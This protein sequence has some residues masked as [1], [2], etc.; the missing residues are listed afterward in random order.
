MNCQKRRLTF[1]IEQKLVVDMVAA[2]LCVELMVGAVAAQTPIAEATRARVRA[3]QASRSAIETILV[4]GTMIRGRIITADD[5]SFTMGEE[6]TNREVGLRYA[7]VLEVK[8]RSWLSGNT[9]AGIAAAVVGGA[10]VVLCFAP[11]PLG[12]LC[13]EDPS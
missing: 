13:Q 8:K 10:L 2:A 5:D 7:Q 1:Q 4:D 9:K 6:K 3:L 11:F 12:F